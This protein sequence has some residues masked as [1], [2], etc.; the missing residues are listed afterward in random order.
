MGLGYCGPALRIDWLAAYALEQHCIVVQST[1][2]FWMGT[3]PAVCPTHQKWVLSV[4]VLLVWRADCTT[5]RVLGSMSV[6]HLHQAVHLESVTRRY[7]ASDF[8]GRSSRPQC[9]VLFRISWPAG[10]AWGVVLRPLDGCGD[11]YRLGCAG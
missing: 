10:V 9:S 6:Q 3:P 5:V 8:R 7:S 4:S 2:M 1:E 11:C